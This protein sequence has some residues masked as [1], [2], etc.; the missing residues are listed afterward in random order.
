M[1]TTKAM[2]NEAKVVGEG[3]VK[4]NNKKKK[5]RKKNKKKEWTLQ[6]RP[7]NDDDDDDDDDDENADDDD[8]DHHQH[9]SHG[10]RAASGGAM[11]SG[12]GRKVYNC[13]QN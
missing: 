12:T 10:V 13:C 11:P 4:G 7:E 5:K 1:P 6:K 8:D 9:P 2:E 3:K